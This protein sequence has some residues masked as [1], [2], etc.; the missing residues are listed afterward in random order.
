M[1]EQAAVDALDERRELGSLP[2]MSEVRPGRRELLGPGR[3]LRLQATGT[4]P[5][6]AEWR[7]DPTGD[8]LARCRAGGEAAVTPRGP[9]TGPLP[10]VPGG[11][12]SA[13][14]RRGRRGLRGRRA[15]RPPAGGAGSG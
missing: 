4:A 11:G 12:R 6:A 14:G 15:A 10:A 5:E 8:A 13:A 3:T 7:M 1:D 2:R 9:F